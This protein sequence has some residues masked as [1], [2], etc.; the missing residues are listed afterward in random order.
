MVTQRLGVCC[1]SGSWSAGAMSTA[2]RPAPSFTACDEYC[3]GQARRSLGNAV[4]CEL[5]TWQWKIPLRRQVLPACVSR[6]PLAGAIQAYLK[7][8]KDHLQTG[9]A[10]RPTAAVPCSPRTA[11]AQV[12]GA[13]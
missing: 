13:D 10:C 5:L 12:S 11:A 7:F 6:N 4:N 1:S 2:G 9:V 3:G 8:A